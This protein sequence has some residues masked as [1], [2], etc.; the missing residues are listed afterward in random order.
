MSTEEQPEKKRGPKGGMKHQPGRG[1]ARKSIPV[2]KRR[3][4]RKAVKKQQEQDAEARRAW[5][6]WDALSEDVKRLLGPTGQPRMPRP[7]HDS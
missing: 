3:F 4:A 5:A 7:S 6:E 2:K 1:H